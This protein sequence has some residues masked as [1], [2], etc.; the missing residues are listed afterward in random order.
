[1]NQYEKVAALNPKYPFLAENKAYI[2][3]ATGRYKEALE[4]SEGGA[5]GS[6]NVN[7][8]L[9][10]LPLLHLIQGQYESA[11]AELRRSLERRPDSPRLIE[12]EG[13][14]DLLKGD[15]GSAG[16]VFEEL[17][18]KGEAIP[19]APNQCGRRQLVGMHVLHGEYRQAQKEI[20]EGI[21]MA[22]RSDLAWD[23]MDYRL[24]LA[25]TELQLKRYS[26]VVEA[27]KPALEIARKTFE[28]ENQKFALHLLGS[29][30]PRP[31]P[32]PRSGG[33]RRAASSAHR[34]NS[35]P[36]EHEALRA[37]DG[38]CGPERGASRRG[39]ASF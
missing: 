6:F 2:Y 34:A 36:E 5:A 32:R 16:K 8:F 11:A 26:R 33:H 10:Y 12:L 13:I 14:L 27:S 31:G 21:E 30:V 9:R 35:L 25:Y 24:L 22:R 39:R 20:S 4:L 38:T 3:A 29:R 15:F 1:M 19:E 17:R 18:R 7:F 23:E 37:L 28:S